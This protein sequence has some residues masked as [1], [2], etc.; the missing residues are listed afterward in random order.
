MFNLPLQGQDDPVEFRGESKS[1]EPGNI[2]CIDFIVNNFDSIA[3]MQF[4]LNFE[5][6]LLEFEIVNTFGDLSGF[7]G[8]DRF[9][10]CMTPGAW[11][12]PHC[13]NEGTF[14]NALWTTND[15]SAGNSLPDGTRLFEICFKIKDD[16]IPGQCA[17]LNINSYGLA[18]R[19]QGIEIFD[20]NL[21]QREFVLVSGEI[22][23][24]PPASAITQADILTICPSGMGLNNGEFSIIVYGGN[25]PYTVDIN[26]SGN[27]ETIQN[28]GDIYTKTGLGPG[29]YDVQVFD[30]TGAQIAFSV[31][32]EDGNSIEFSETIF[33]PTCF[34]LDNGRIEVDVEGGL[35]FAGGTYKFEW[36]NSLIDFATRG[37]VT[38]LA[39]GIY[40][41]TI[42]DSLG[43]SIIGNFEL[44]TEPIQLSVFAT[45]PFCEGA[46]GNIRIEVTGGTGSY[47]A[48]L[49]DVP[50]QSS[51][52]FPNSTTFNNLV[53]AKYLIALED[54]QNDDCFVID[55]VILLFEN[56]I[57]LDPQ[58]TNVNCQTQSADYEIA[59]TNSD[60]SMSTNFDYQVFDLAGPTLLD[61]ASTGS[62][63]NIITLTN[64]PFSSGGYE[65]RILSSEGCEIIELLPSA[66][67][68]GVLS[69]VNEPTISPT[70][71]GQAN[72]SIDIDV[73][74]GSP[75]TYTFSNG[76]TGNGNSIILANLDTG[77]YTVVIA[78]TDGCQITFSFDILAKV[79]NITSATNNSLVCTDLTGNITAEV[80][81]GTQP[82][83]FEWDHP[84]NDNSSTLPNVAAGNSYTLI[85]TDAS[86]CSSS[87]S[88]ALSAAD[89]VII[90]NFNINAPNC[91]GIPNGSVEA[92]ASGGSSNNGMYTFTWSDGTVETIPSTTA[93]FDFNLGSGLHWLVVDDGEC[94][95]DTIFFT[96][97]DG[98]L[99]KVDLD[100]SSIIPP[101]CD[102]NVSSVFIEVTPEIDGTSFTFSFPELGIF[103]SPSPSQNT[104][105]TGD[106]VIEISDSNGC[107]NL[108]TFTVTP[109][110][111]LLARVDSTASLIPICADDES[112]TIVIDVEGGSGNYSFIWTN[113]NANSN[114]AM[115]LGIGTYSVLVTDD[116]GCSA[117]VNDIIITIPLPVV[118]SIENFDPI[119]TGDRGIIYVAEVSGGTGEGYSYQVNTDPVLAI[120]DTASVF[121]EDYIVRVYDS[122]GCSFESSP[123]SVNQASELFVFLG[124]DRTISL[125]NDIELE[126]MVSIG[127][128]LIDVEW[129]PEETLIFL[130]ENGLNVMASPLSDQTFQVQVTYENGCTATDEISIFVEKATEIFVP[131]AFTSDQ[132]KKKHGMYV[133]VGPS[134]ESINSVQIFDRWGSMVHAMNN[135][136]TPNGE[137]RIWGGSL[138]GKEANSGVYIYRIGYTLKGG[139]LGVL[140]GDV[141]LLR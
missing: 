47:N 53:P 103:N 94:V 107:T 134:I 22:C 34:D 25:A 104:L 98:P 62:G 135:V 18:S 52:G 101:A 7:M 113:T 141:T 114:T 45:N 74:S 121:P 29:S 77:S 3:G 31:N 61:M 55:S 85:V 16:A 106:I 14:L 81:G 120:G 92:M 131:N 2:V 117:E 33:G 130:S 138:K 136:D 83:M 91:F 11:G 20:P 93:A 116:D 76:E 67:A 12:P 24:T 28:S 9:A 13:T 73:T 112:A 57:I 6:D 63:S 88:L 54:A 59:I 65:I 48:N 89:A 100:K 71:E 42:T 137:M 39:N 119:C 35:P 87:Q 132:T 21:D 97:P 49:L 123:F 27:I 105:G 80:N 133:F 32:I 8:V 70:C 44:L 82:Y 68:T 1:G 26:A 126:A 72:G 17:S 79:I 75:V 43:C 78:N 4:T 46:T 99:F 122:E 38:N 124:P 125:G 36:N 64:V 51:F 15:F 96:M 102:G 84:N 108:D 110:N 58:I 66:S 5:A 19:E 60:G 50:F 10:N 111:P 23:I 118:A 30:A 41:V 95:S 56:S 140:I 115:D 86:G 109:L 69:L 90:D 40:E 128:T 129:T 127:V 139:D 37:V